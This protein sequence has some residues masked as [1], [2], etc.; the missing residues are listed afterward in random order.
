MATFTS[1][2]NILP[3]PVSKITDQ[4]DI[5]A[6][7]VA[8]PGFSALNF[9]SNGETQVSRTNSGRGVMRDQEVQ[10]W[11]F[12]I[13][14]N[15]MFRAQFDPVDAF[16]AS[17]NARRDPFFVS[18]PQYSKP[19]GSTFAT[20]SGANVV[21]VVGATAAGSSTILIDTPVTMTSYPQPGD[22]FSINDSTNVNHM[23]VYKITRVETAARYQASTT[24][25]G[26]TQ[27]RIHISPRLQRAT[28][29]NAVI[30]FRPLFRVISTS[31]LREHELNTDNLY[32][33]SLD[34]EE[35][36]P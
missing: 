3:D 21:S 18:L 9:R 20:F 33:F 5:D 29:D 31:D 10:Y 7:G 16:L 1:F 30:N 15:P 17:R 32:S 22:M 14:Y 6:T 34:L 36:Q 28:A 4:G 27:C 13:R 23:K 12:S 25:P 8:G 24:P 26:A 11:S 19:K 2:S 35:I